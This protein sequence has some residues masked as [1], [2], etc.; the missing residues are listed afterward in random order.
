MSANKISQP[1]PFARLWDSAG[2]LVVLAVLFLI[3][4]LFVDNF[5]TVV[6]LRGLA[7]AVATIG[8]VACTMMFCL[9]A[10][11]FDLS[12]G[13]VVAFAGVLGAT[14]M[15]RTGSVAAGVAAAL[16]A[17]ALTG[18][19]NGLFVARLGINALITTLAS[20]Q[21]VR[22]LGFIA[23]DG[24]AIGIRTDAFFALGNTA[25]LGVPVPVWLTI[26]CFTVFGVLLNL[27]AFGRNALAIG[28]NK[29]AAH[30]AGVAVTRIKITIF[31]L[32]GLIAAF[33]GLVLAARMTS[34][35]PNTSQGLELEVISACVLGGVSLSGGVARIGAV[36]AGVLIMGIV[37]NAMNLL[38]IPPFYQYV[39]R[40]V[41][42]LGAVML[43]RLKQRT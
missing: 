43:D 30:L 36:I 3:C 25:W 17:G 32:Q 33:A 28:G 26:A 6:N 41:I 18:F 34:G 9:A 16:G 12:V 29:E 1:S 42:L 14:V 27:T 23:S 19:A 40:G 15:N 22:G 7:L 5:L 4:A 31:T 24:R 11:D 38:N 37:Q 10:G 39:A 35:Q 20:M 21:I 13:S 8:M 2:M